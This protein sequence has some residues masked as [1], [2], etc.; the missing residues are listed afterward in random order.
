M[1]GTLKQSWT[2]DV[3]LEVLAAA[4]RNREILKGVVT[5]V[6][7]KSTRV[8]E[9]GKYVQKEMEVA[10]FLIE[11]SS[12]KAYCSAH[13]F[14]EHEFRSLSG[15]VGSFQEFIVQDIL[16]DDQIAFISV[17]EADQIKKEVFWEELI[18]AD[19]K[20]KLS[21]TTYQGVISGYNP[22]TQNI[23]VRINGMDC[24]MRRNDWDHGRVRDIASLV[25]RGTPVDVK[26]IRIDK[27][28][29]LVQVSKRATT[30]DPFNQ[31]EPL[32]NARAIAG[33]VTTVHAIHGIFIKLDNGLE[34]KG[35]K[36]SNI[37]EPVVG[38]IVTCRI[39]TIDKK[40]RHCKVVITGYPR[41]KKNRK[42]LG[43][44]L[45]E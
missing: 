36:P 37:E 16:L 42:D 38:D 18:N 19:Q 4:R 11:N 8:L 22:E 14:S 15:F 40:N 41:G 26:V 32:R 24:F 30:E 45:F 2:D 35:L 39:R 31:L 3:E 33:K 44:F 34:V 12:I 7:T 21:E 9:E 1:E 23:F 5:S 25:D 43:G 17:R 10:E 20:D 6:S 29:N 27:E 13:E 28:R